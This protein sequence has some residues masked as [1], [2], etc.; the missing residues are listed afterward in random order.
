MF[1]KARNEGRIGLNT[2]MTKWISGDTDIGKVM[3]MRKKISHSNFPRYNSLDEHTTHVLQC[4]YEDTC[5]M[6]LD[7]LSEFRVWLQS[8]HT[9][10]DI[11]CFLFHGLK[12]WLILDTSSNH[13][14]YT[15]DPSLQI[16]FRTQKLI[17]WE[18][19][20]KVFVVTGM[21]SYQQNHYTKMGMTKQAN[22]GELS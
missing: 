12:S 6:R 18:A 13:N 2:F 16:I 21:I 20:L 4:Q 3:R 15:G 8:V 10:I 22:G 17:G 11:K 14:N 7:I 19:L 1:E 9:Y 5:S